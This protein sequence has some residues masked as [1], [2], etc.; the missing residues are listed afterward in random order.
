VNCSQFE[1]FLDQYLDGELGG[2][3]KL[4]FE[5][6]LMECKPCGHLFAMMEAAGAI[7]AQPSPEEPQLSEGF[8]D[9]VLVR[10]QTPQV[11]PVNFRRILY[12]V[13]A[14]ASV[15][16]AITGTLFLAHGRSNSSGLPG[17]GALMAD[18]GHQGINQWLAGTLEQAGSSLWELK[19]LQSTAVN[20]VKQGLFK[21]LAGP[22]QASEVT[23]EQVTPAKAVD[24]SSSREPQLAGLQLL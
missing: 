3:L 6:H 5:A 18:I 1:H 22:S 2:S 16:L 4:E 8:A 19:E 23:R 20:Q 9:Q 12:R 14:A 11:R 24:T 10:M 7:I 17:D 21:S 15:A 13:S